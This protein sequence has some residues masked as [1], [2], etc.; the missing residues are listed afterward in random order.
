MVIGSRGAS[1]GGGELPYVVGTYVGNQS[2][3]HVINVG[4]SPSAVLIFN[5]NINTTS[6]RH[7][8]LFTKNTPAKFDQYTVA[9]TNNNGFE[10]VDGLY[11]N[12]YGETYVYIAFK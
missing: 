4:F 11:M 3:S 6:E 8:T 5:Q 2:T 10:L 1:G 7:N 9:Q 12:N